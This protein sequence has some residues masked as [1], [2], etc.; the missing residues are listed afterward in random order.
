MSDFKHPLMR[1]N[2]LKSDLSPVIDLLRSEEPKLT[3][4]PK[5]E[6]F[7]KEW[8]EW[9]GCKYSVF[10]NSG[11]SANLLC[12]ALLK[13]KYPDGGKVIVPPFTWSSDISSLI[14]MGFEPFFVDINLKTLGLDSKKVINNLQTLNDVRA[15]FITHAQGLNALDS[16]LIEFIDKNEI[17]LIEDVC[18][19]HGVVLPNQMKAGSYGDLSCFSFYYAHHLSTIEGGMICTNDES[20]YQILRMLRSHGMLRESNNNYLKDS[21]TKK[22]PDLNPKFIFT[23]PAFNVRNNEIGAIIGLQQLKRIE[24]IVQ[25]RASNFEKFLSL[26]PNWIFKDFLLDGQSNYAFNIILNEPDINLFKRLCDKFHEYRIEFRIG[27]AGGGNQMRQPY[28]REIINLTEN[29]IKAIAP[30][31]DH[32]HFFGMY[33]GNFPDL[34]QSE[35]EWLCKVIKDV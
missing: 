16:E 13:E 15:I 23:R 12:L 22:F 35:I 30:I 17:F 11:S 20:Y 10:V 1:N 27:S 7:E 33:I 28:V 32:V 14:W 4:G 2:I 3:S 19:S 24:Q 25:K 29:E 8:S 26:C 31:S 18:E 6:E 21:I 5:V 9:L 34:G